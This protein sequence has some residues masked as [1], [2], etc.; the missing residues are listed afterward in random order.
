MQNQPYSR[1]VKGFAAPGFGSPHPARRLRGRPLLWG[2]GALA[3]LGFLGWLGLQ[4]QPPPFPPAFP[5]PGVTR[6]VPLPAGLPGPVD[7]Y[8]RQTYGERL[9]VITSAVITGRATLRPVPGGPTFPA[10]FR[11]IH[12]AGRNYRHY[13]EATWFGL[14]L[15]RVNEAYLDGVSRREMPRPLPSSTGDPKGA[16]A[17]NLGLWSE[18]L[19]MPAVYLTDPRVRWE[20]V[21]DTTALLRLPFGQAEETYVVRF[22][23]VTGRPAMME[24]MR[25]Q[26]AADEAKTLW[27]NLTLSWAEFGGVT[28]PGKAAAHWLNQARPWAVFTAEQVTYNADVGEAVRGRGP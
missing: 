9:P 13:I 24:V 28:L 27:L 20:A 5:G 17:A 8:Y 22:D 23:P 15:L 12:E 7:R 21:D 16:Q 25:Y 1:Q 26:N 4:V 14:P 18:T 19:W 6:T 3:G 11:F 10:R 2:A